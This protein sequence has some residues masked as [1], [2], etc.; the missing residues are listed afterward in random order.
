MDSVKIPKSL[1]THIVSEFLSTTNDHIKVIGIDG[2]TAVGKTIFANSLTN[3]FIQEGI[4]TFIFQLDWSLINRSDRLND[5][6]FIKRTN[7]AFSH[8]SSIHM[9]LKKVESFLEKIQIFNSK[10]VKNPKLEEEVS[11]SN[12]YSRENSGL[13]NGFQNFLLSANSVF[14][15]EGH[16]TLNTNLHQY[17]DKNILLLANQNSLL[18]R[19][20][21]R[22]KKY[23]N[24]SEAIDY[25]WRI[26]LPSYYH[27]LKFFGNNSDHIIIND[28]FA[29]PIEH[30]NHYIKQWINFKT[31]S[32]FPNINPS[33]ESDFFI[34]LFENSKLVDPKIKSALLHSISFIKEW[35]RSVSEYLRTN[36]Y[37]LKHDINTITNNLILS[38]NQKF[39]NYFLKI[40]HTN[41]FHNLYFQKLPLSLAF[42]LNTLD[43]KQTKLSFLVDSNQHKV[44]LQLIWSGGYRKVIC[45]RELG[46]ISIKQ[47]LI[48]KFFD[49]FNYFPDEEVINFYTPTDFTI[50]SFVRSYN[51][52]TIFIQKEDEIISPSEIVEKL[53]INGGIWVHRFALF[54]ELK[55]YK[56]IIKNLGAQTISI[57]NYLISIRHNNKSL[58][59]DFES[60]KKTWKYSLGFKSIYDKSTREMDDITIHQRSDAANFVNEVCHNFRMM[61]GV[62]FSQFMFADNDTIKQALKEIKLMLLSENRFLRKRIT[63]FIL[64]FFPMMSLK[65]NEL[66]DDLAK[67]LKGCEISLD[68]LNKLSPSILAEVYLWLSL[69]GNASAILGATSYDIGRSCSVDIESYLKASAAFKSPIVIQA[70]INAIGQLEK[71][72]NGK[73]YQGYL[74]LPHGPDDFIVS[75]IKSARDIYLY[76]GILPPLFGIGL[77]HVSSNHDIPAGRA[78]RFL[79]KALKTGQ[80]THF[81]E[82]GSSLFKAS[83][84]KITTLSNS[85][86]RMA[87]FSSNLIEDLK[88]TLLVDREICIGELNYID[89]SKF[90]LIPTINELRLFVEIYLQTLEKKG[91]AALLCR[92]TLF[93]ANLGTTHHGRDTGTPSVFLAEKWRDGLK[94]TNFI[95]PVLHG[96]TDSHKDILK[97]AS[98][99]CHKINVAGDLLNKFIENLPESLNRKIYDARVDPKLSFHT[100]RKDLDIINLNQK[101][102]IQRGLINK[103]TD[104]LETIGSPKF[105]NQD[106]SYFRYSNFKY[107][108]KHAEVILNSI[109]T[110]INSFKK[111]P[112]LKNNTKCYFSASMIEVPEERMKGKLLE[113]LWACGIKSF[114]IDAGDGQFVTRKFC[115]LNKTRILK[116][117]FPK[118]TLHAHLMIKN[119]HFPVN[120]D[121]SAIQKY[122]EAGCNSIAVHPRSFD[123][124]DDIPIAINLIRNLKCRAGIVLEVGD[125][126]HRKKLDL[127][128]NNKID[129]IIIMGVPIGYGGQL[130]N[131]T[132]LQTIQ[133]IKNLSSNHKINDMLIEVDG[134]LTPHIA[135]LCKNAGAQVFAG[136][137]LVKAKSNIQMSDKINDLKDIL[138]N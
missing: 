129:W 6:N 65:V 114:H 55:F 37:E 106:F 125:V 77:D 44:T 25:F 72:S 67:D 84:R 99:G 73:V 102:E 33:K 80:I 28:D 26:D 103:T 137:S 88:S 61:D 39:S 79:S 42:S 98:S 132:S 30:S 95:S 29:K 2:P 4:K 89:G 91:Y 31:D 126:L 128:I 85:Y 133:E 56:A 48:F 51:L 40:E 53:T 9:D 120:G 12:L 24:P 35:D 130:F 101:K 63:Q 138:S 124:Q 20:I 74:K 123:I 59:S 110:L 113:T 117:R 43:N 57:G 70:S 71:D 3:K 27:H 5:L 108:K 14:I 66:W 90:A 38:C 18:E 81:V 8:E 62:I 13:C 32:I 92:P 121:L 135:K 17:I 11:L 47:K 104:L 16:Y 107:S 15:F 94:N 122:A 34:S 112:N 115:G 21:D 52:N 10:L 111:Q 49:E 46:K 131:F 93:V 23:R 116:K 7:F 60:F 64:R 86:K 87:E 134:G 69:R 105:S 58:I 96:T 127:I 76:E 136:W 82:D 54:S 109:S 119:P 78:K 41:C 1:I 36:V 75:A 100:L 22:V 19:K 68:L 118:T 97:L 50:P 83:D 45:K